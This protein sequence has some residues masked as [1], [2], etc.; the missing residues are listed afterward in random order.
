MKKIFTL[1]LGLLFATVPCLAQ[2]EEEID[3]S[4]QF[5]YADGTPVANGATVT[6]KNYA[7]QDPFQGQTVMKSG[8]YVKNTSED[9]VTL[10][11]EINVEELPSGN[12]QLCFP[13]NCQNFGLGK[14]ETSKGV[15]K[16]DGTLYDLQTEWFASSYGTAK[17]T[18]KLKTYVFTGMHGLTPSYDFNGDGPSVTVVYDYSE[19][20]T[21]GIHDVKDGALNG[22]TEYFDLQGRRVAKPGKGLYVAKKGGESKTVIVK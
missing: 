3:E 7:E 9:A 21:L 12:V 10:A 13:T 17:V 19:N 14:N 16:A 20:S 1:A 18:Y 5:V 15:V 11:V 8:L 2:E 6:V 4:C 22:T